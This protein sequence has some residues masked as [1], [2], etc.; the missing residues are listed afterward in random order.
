MS[1][2]RAEEAPRPGFPPRQSKIKNALAIRMKEYAMSK[3][4]SDLQADVVL[5]TN[6]GK[7]LRAIFDNCDNCGAPL[8]VDE[9][10]RV[11]QVLRPYEYEDL[12]VMECADCTESRDCSDD[13]YF[14]D[15]GAIVD[16][17]TEKYLGGGSVN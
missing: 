6:D 1:A 10:D 16:A 8:T 11:D 13:E 5:I 4:S 3:V 12:I 17:L 2:I 15:L 14:T 9:L 7:R